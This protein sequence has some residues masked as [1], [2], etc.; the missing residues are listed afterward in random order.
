[1]ANYSKAIA[2]AIVHY[3]D[4]EGL[5]YTFDPER[6]VIKA[7]F[8]ISKD[9]IIGSVDVLIRI[10]EDDFI[11]SGICPINATANRRA[12]A[13]ELLT[14]LNWVLRNGNFEMDYS[15]GE[16]RYKVYV[17]CEG[18]I[19]SSDVIEAAVHIPPS[20]FSQYG[21]SIA[22]VLT[23]QK[24][25]ETAFNDRNA[26]KKRSGGGS[27]GSGGLDLGAL[28]DLLDGLRGSGL[29]DDE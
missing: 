1:M 13:A 20:M 23:G 29:G 12:D 27:G 18:L 17:D 22:D 25:P 19:P 26:G 8:S 10:H 3:M 15:D 5:K 6:G 14:R 11:S 21:Q 24:D 9:C 4:S 7:G 16:I 28:R 2:D